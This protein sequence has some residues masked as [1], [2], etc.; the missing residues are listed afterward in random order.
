MEMGKFI[1]YPGSEAYPIPRS[2]PPPHDRDG[3]RCGPADHGGADPG[4]VRG[5]GGPH[6]REVS[7][8]APRSPARSARTW[9]RCSTPAIRTASPRSLETLYR[10]VVILGGPNAR[11]PAWCSRGHPQRHECRCAGHDHRPQHLG[12][13][14][15]GARHCCPVCH[16]ARGGDGRSGCASP[17]VILRGRLAPR[18]RNLARPCR[19]DDEQP[20]HNAWAVRH[21]CARRYPFCARRPQ[22]VHGVV[23]RIRIRVV[24]MRSLHVSGVSEATTCLSRASPDQLQHRGGP[25]A[26]RP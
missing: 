4:L 14:G 25:R 13:R 5:Q 11:Q 2:A 15:A 3:P 10:P 18:S 21:A 22:R 16:R 17:G 6:T 20:M 12:G 9:S 23:P 26:R 1:F 19:A 7:A 24:A 8:R